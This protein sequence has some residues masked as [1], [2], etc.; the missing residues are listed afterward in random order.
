MEPISHPMMLTIS[1][2]SRSDLQLIKTFGDYQLIQTQSVKPVK[3]MQIT[4][5]CPHEYVHKLHSI[6]IDFFLLHH[7]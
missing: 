1:G 3:I 2:Y 4:K 6:S 7:W 5:D